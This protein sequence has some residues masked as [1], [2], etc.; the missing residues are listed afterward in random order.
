MILNTP[1]SLIAISVHRCKIAVSHR[2]MLSEI[3]V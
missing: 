3:I 1:N 2:D